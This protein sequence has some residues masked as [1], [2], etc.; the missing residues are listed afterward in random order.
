LRL[1]SGATRDFCRQAF[2]VTQRDGI[3]LDL[4]VRELGWEPSSELDPA[5][6]PAFRTR[7]LDALRRRRWPVLTRLE[8]AYAERH[9]ALQL[10]G[11]IRLRPPKDFEGA[12]WRL[13]VAFT[14]PTD[15][16]QA[17][18]LLCD[19]LDTRPTEI[20]GLFDLPVV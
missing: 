3:P 16:R 17:V 18:D 7:F 2:E 5:T 8:T 20:Q 6:L 11:T 12:D 4:L 13:E 1:S 9:R 15:L 19:R 10:P 14:N